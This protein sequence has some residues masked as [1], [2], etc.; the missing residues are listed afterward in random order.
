MAA[1][2]QGLDF[3]VTGVSGDGSV[4][5]GYGAGSSGGTEALSWSDGTTSGLGFLS[6]L[7]SYS[8]AFGTNYDGSVVVGMSY[9]SGYGA[10]AYAYQAFRSVDGT[11]SGLGF[12]SGLVGAESVANAVSGDGSV[13]VGWS[14]SS[15]GAI[16]PGDR[17]EAFRW[18]ASSMT[19]LGYLPGDYRTIANGTNAD[20]SVVV[21]YSTGGSIFRQAFVWTA[22]TG[23]VGLGFLPGAT[24]HDSIA[25]AVSADGSVI[26]GSSSDA[27]GQ[28]E[29]FRW[30]NG[31]MTGLGV[32]P[33][34]NYSTALATNSDGSV[35]VGV[36]GRDFLWD[37][38]FG[39]Q[40]LYHVLVSEYGLNL[41]GWELDTP[42]GISA[43]GGTIVGDGVAPNGTHQGFVVSGLLVNR[44]VTG[45][46]TVASGHHDA[47]GTLGGNGA[48]GIG[49]DASL[50]IGGNNTSSDPVQF[51]NSV[52]SGSIAGSG[53][54]I[55]D[56][57]GLW[58]FTGSFDAGQLSIDSGTVEIAA[59]FSGNV[60]FATNSRGILKLDQPLSFTGKISG[61]TAG[62]YVD[63]T[64]IN[65]ADHPIT[66]K[67]ANKTD[68]LTV[69]DPHTKVS[70]TITLMGD[71]KHS[72]FT[73]T[74]DGSGGT[75]I[76]AQVSKNVAPGGLSPLTN[77][78]IDS[79][80]P[81][82][83]THAQ[84]VALLGQHMASSFVM[85]SDGHG[86]ALITDAPPHQQPFLTH[87]HA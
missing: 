64:N 27:S 1:Q 3:Y 80:G 45:T 4:V 49:L 53:D 51:P 35:V 30:Q 50:S 39:M 38:V 78:L 10:N 67:Y 44:F 65:F 61:L 74:S 63:L 15:H 48:V 81:Q 36:S 43:D 21:G 73:L 32:L 55:K 77:S 11:M 85:A 13:V 76:T 25:T 31:T 47:I 37:Q 7:P 18:T 52:F 86:G 26:V 28:G 62:D 9:Y 66:T 29:A 82:Q 40:D 8:Q 56:G 54:L 68:Q 71:Y 20:G 57:T 14:Q 46:Y 41:A 24:D 79:N 34:A 23:M 22:A 72:D 5:V 12:L 59:A 84:S 19:G 17:Y 58:L 70:D 83:D 69:T 60:N 2:F 75:L 33:G 87:P 42:T 16:T 6:L